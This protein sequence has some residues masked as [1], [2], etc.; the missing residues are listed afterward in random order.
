MMI[1]KGSLSFIDFLVNMIL[2]IKHCSNL[3]EPA[4]QSP[5]LQAMPGGL[6]QW[7]NSD[8]CPGATCRENAFVAPTFPKPG[9]CKGL[10]LAGL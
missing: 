1:L 2:P 10:K 9:L 6:P 7:Q 3:P 4:S 5:S 8:A